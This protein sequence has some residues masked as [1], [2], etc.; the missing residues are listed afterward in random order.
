LR[1]N[2]PW[3]TTVCD[4]F[5][6]HSE[7]C[8]VPHGSWVHHVSVVLHHRFEIPTYKT[9]KGY[10]GKDAA[11]ICGSAASPKVG[12]GATVGTLKTGYPRV[13]VPSQDERQDGSVCPRVLCLRLP[14]PNSG[15]LQSHHVPHGPGSRLLAQGST[16]AATYLMDPASTTRPRGRFGTTTC[17]LGSRSRLLA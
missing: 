11:P 13:Q 6:R 17:P 8:T 7:H 16:E 5:A 12:P 2:S 10:T 1:S 9:Q 14:P 15:E 3:G 4:G